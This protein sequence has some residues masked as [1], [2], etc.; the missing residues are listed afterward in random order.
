[1]TFNNDIKNLA[2]RLK[3]YK[4]SIDNEENT[5]TALVLPMLK[6]LRY[7][8]HNPSELRCEYNASF[9]TKPAFADYAIVDGNGKALI[10]IEVKSLGTQL[11]Q[12]FGQLNAYYCA[13]YPDFCVLTD[14]NEYRIYTDSEKKNVLDTEPSLVLRLDKPDALDGFFEQILKQGYNCSA[15]KKTA[16]ACKMLKA[17]PQ[18]VPQ[19]TPQPPPGLTKFQQDLFD[20]IKNI[21]STA[22]LHGDIKWHPTQ[23]YVAIR[24]QGKSQGFCFFRFQ[25]TQT[26]FI[27]K[28]NTPNER[29]F[30]ITS[31]QDIAQHKD[32][33]IKYYKEVTGIQGV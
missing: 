21:I 29:K 15:S 14:G 32:D 12:N 22:Q 11:D 13:K 6:A 19:P 26:L 27:F 17:T 31:V 30:K 18:P 4:S 16:K 24:P 1:M 28:I 20:E 9:G 5:K 3:L 10:L 25:K 8:I 33:I 23:F 2:A 7:D